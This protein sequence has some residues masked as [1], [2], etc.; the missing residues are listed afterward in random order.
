VTPQAPLTYWPLSALIN[1]R[2]DD[3]SLT[4]EKTDLIF[5]S[6]FKSLIWSAPSC[7]FIP[8]SLV[9]CGS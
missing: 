5:A 1:E 9:V 3:A 4:D 6:S 7:A 8:D 2:N